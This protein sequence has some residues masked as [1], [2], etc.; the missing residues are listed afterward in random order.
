MTTMAIIMGLGLIGL[1]GVVIAA[2]LG[3]ARGD[4]EVAA[5]QRQLR[6]AIYPPRR[7]CP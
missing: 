6:E 3:N 2:L 5:R 7:G 4:R 1:G